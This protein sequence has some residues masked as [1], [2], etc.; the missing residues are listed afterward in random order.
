V[1]QFPSARLP[2][3]EFPDDSYKSNPE[4]WLLSATLS[5]NVLPV[6]STTST[7]ESKFVTR[8]LLAKERRRELEKPR[9]SSVAGAQL[10]IRLNRERRCDQKAS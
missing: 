8:Q 1:N 6:V 10:V 9:S 5:M 3:N 4:R 2:A 7:P